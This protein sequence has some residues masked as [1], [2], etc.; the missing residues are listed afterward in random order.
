MSTGVIYSGGPRALNTFDGSSAQSILDG[1]RNSLLATGWSLFSSFPGSGATT[2]YK[3]NSALSIDLLQCRI[4]LAYNAN[5]IPFGPGVVEV[6]FSDNSESNIGYIHYLGIVALRAYYIISC[7]YQLF[8]FK[9]N[10]VVSFDA[11]TVMGGI[12]SSPKNTTAAFWSMGNYDSSGIS[13]QNTFIQNLTPNATTS[14]YLYNSKFTIGA[15][16]F[17]PQLLTTQGATAGSAGS[18]KTNKFASGCYPVVLPAIV[19]GETSTTKPRIRGYLWD[20]VVVGTSFTWGLQKTFDGH[21]FINLTDNNIY[22]SLWICYTP[23]REGNPV[24]Y[25]Y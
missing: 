4:K 1:I 3:L 20:A 8:I 24:G 12:P 19:Y 21:G 15:G 23:D 7:P 9:D 22:G 11:Y 18:G 25:A 16:Q 13:F 6:T 14:T 5:S 17:A 10:S 2:G